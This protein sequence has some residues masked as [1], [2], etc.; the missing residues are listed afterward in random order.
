VRCI[1]IQFCWNLFTEFVPHSINI[2]VGTDRSS[3]IKAQDQYRSQTLRLAKLWLKF[4]SQ[5]AASTDS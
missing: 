4:L 2:E 5:L 1:V 3:R